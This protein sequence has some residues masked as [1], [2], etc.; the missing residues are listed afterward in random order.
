M[1]V[2]K[3]HDIMCKHWYNTESPNQNVNIS[4]MYTQNIIF[5]RIY[6]LFFHRNFL[7]PKRE[8]TPLDFMLEH[9]CGSYKLNL[10]TYR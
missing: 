1:P 6:K 3:T 8:N 5:P 2:M 4:E 9:T 10:Q 7:T